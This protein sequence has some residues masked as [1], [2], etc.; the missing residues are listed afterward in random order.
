MS[1]S[2]HDS[3]MRSQA[4]TAAGVMSLSRRD[5]NRRSQSVNAA[6][7]L[8]VSHHAGMTA[9]AEARSQRAGIGSAGMQRRHRHVVMTGGSGGSSSSSSDGQMVG[10]GEVA[11]WI[12]GE[13]GKM[14]GGGGHAAAA[15]AGV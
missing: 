1:A 7:V 8:T 14:R 6:G 4:A 9:A 10:I 11:A 2:L 3:S 15:A 13:V 12:G 5:T